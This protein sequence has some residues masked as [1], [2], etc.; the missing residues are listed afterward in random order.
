MENHTEAIRKQACISNAL[1]PL[2][3]RRLPGRTD[4]QGCG[5]GRL[6]TV[7]ALLALPDAMQYPVAMNLWHLPIIDETFSDLPKPRERLYLVE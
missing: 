6:P 1:E 2:C 3:L 7:R 5:A 4:R